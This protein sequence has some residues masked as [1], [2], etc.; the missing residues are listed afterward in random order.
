[1]SA[2]RA[3]RRGSVATSRRP[4]A[5]VVAAGLAL[6]ALAGSASA[7]PVS[8]AARERAQNAF[9]VG[10][11]Q[12]L[13][14]ILGAGTT[15]ADAEPLYLRDVVWR[16]MATTPRP[17]P[18]DGSLS[19]RRIR[20]MVEEFA[21]GRA[22]LS[23]YPLPKAGEADPYPRLTGLVLERAW[24]ESR[25]ARGLPD[26]GPLPPLH[27]EMLDWLDTTY[28]KPLYQGDVTHLLPPE[29]QAEER[30]ARGRLADAAERARSIALVSVGGLVL[31]ATAA[32]LLLGRGRKR[33]PAAADL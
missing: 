9:I 11:V 10:R 23:A 30:A 18:D 16:P 33:P 31:A 14:A 29:A 21:T 6:L 15:P 8:D 24:R 25:G 2:A 4:A 5:C 28:A 3:R 19:S 13:D 1:M 7:G 27:D 32:G 12:D 20:W 26:D 22:P 17:P